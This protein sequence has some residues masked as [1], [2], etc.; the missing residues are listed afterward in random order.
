LGARH[1]ACPGKKGKEPVEQLSIAICDDEAEQAAYL[2]S[3]A[4]KWAAGRREPVGIAGFESGESFLFRYEDEGPFQILLLDIQMAG[5]DGLSL[6]KKLREKGD[7]AQIVFITGF[8]DYAA[9]GYE[10]SALHYLRKPVS[11]EKLFQVLDRA[12]SRLDRQ[13]KQLLLPVQGEIRRVPVSAVLYCESFGHTSS[14]VTREESL[15]L[16]MSLTELEE[17]LQ[18]ECVRCHRCYLVGIRHISRIS[19]TELILD[20]GKALPLSRRLYRQ[21]NQAFIQY[22]QG[23]ERPSPYSMGQREKE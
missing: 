15:E 8:P 2:K 4:E 10:V 19:K 17:K 20:G 13:E 7:Q 5:V 1:R 21:V 12:V 3:L 23:A 22:F 14:L 6:A 9:E 11:E 16:R 18:G